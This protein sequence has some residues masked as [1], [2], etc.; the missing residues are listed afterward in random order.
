MHQYPQL[1][2][3]SI[4]SILEDGKTI[5]PPPD[6][7]DELLNTQA[8]CFV[9]LHT[10]DGN[11]RGCIGTIKPIRNNLANEIIHNAVQAAT[12]DP[13]FPRLEINDLNNIEISVDVLSKPEEI[14]GPESLD[15][16]K[17]G[18]IVATEDKRTG[19]LLPDLEG[20]DTAEQQLSIAC[21][22]GG[23]DQQKVKIKL[24]RFTVERYK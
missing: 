8:A 20:V 18:V 22:K 1:A 2:Y 7:L 3:Q 17:Y 15:P 14:Y 10:K 5:D 19:L 23:I 9:T 16:K 21:Q 12:G 4:K 24:Y 11:L 6:L 13:R